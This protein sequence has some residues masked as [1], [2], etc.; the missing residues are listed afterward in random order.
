MFALYTS[1]LVSVLRL[2]PVGGL[3]FPYIK[4]TNDSRYVLKSNSGVGICIHYD[5]KNPANYCCVS[6][7]I[8]EGEEIRIEKLSGNYDVGTVF[9]NQGSWGVEGLDSYVVIAI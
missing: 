4:E 6:F 8:K 5:S 9:N 7:G 1:L 2:V 3:K